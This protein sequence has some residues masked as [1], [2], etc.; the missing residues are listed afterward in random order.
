MNKRQF[1]K[2]SL[3]GL[4]ALA[5]LPKA[6]ALEYYP[7]KAK[8][9][10]AIV[11][12]TWCG[13][14]RDAAVWISEGINGIAQVFDV[15]EK[16]DL[17]RYQNI[18]VGGSI[19]SGKVSKE[20]Q[21]FLNANR[22][23]LKNKVRGHFVVCGNRMKPP[24]T[25]QTVDLIDNHLAKLTGVNDVH[26]TVFLGR[27]TYGLLDE[28]SAQMLKGFDMPEYDNLK[29]S[30]CLLFGKQIIERFKI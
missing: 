8:K 17:S 25:K 11:Y 21:E 19:R 1:I 20:M 30:E 7:R 23:I 10:W 24:T 12:S 27:V 14:S 2:R 9:S 29:R 5:V 3:L 16:P 4:S 15:R 22:D 18:I 28:N 13:S 6:K 26:S